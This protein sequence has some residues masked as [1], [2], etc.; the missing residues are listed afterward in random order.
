MIGQA[1]LHAVLRTDFYTFAQR[2]FREVAAGETF[3]PNWHIEAMCHVL[4][5]IGLK[6]RRRQ[7][8][9]VPPRSLKSVCSSVALVAWLLGHDPTRKIIC[10]SYS[11]DLASQF[12]A[13]TRQ[14]MKSSWYA[15]LFPGTVIS[16]G[17]DTERFFRTTAGGYRDSTSVGGTLTGKGADFIIIDDPAKP[18]EMM[19]EALRTSVNDWYDRTLTTR[20]N[21]KRTDGILLVMQRLHP[22][23][24]SGHVKQR[25]GWEVLTLP[26]IAMADETIPLSA[27][28]SH[29]RA[30]GD[31]LDEHREGKADLEERKL[32]LGARAFQAQY[33]Q[34]PL[35][36]DGAII[37][38]AKFKSF[39]VVP[40]LSSGKIV[41]SW[42]CASKSGEFNDFSVCTTWLIMNDSYFLLDIFREKLQFPDLI[43]ATCKLAEA[44]RP[45]DVLIE[46]AA[47]GT[48]LIQQLTFDRPIAMPRP[49]KIT[50]MRD[51]IT[52]LHTV[53]NVVEQGRVLLPLNA[54]WL[55]DFKIE[56]IQF[57]YG[58]FNDQI[59]SLSQ[60]LT[61]AE[62][63]RMRG[64]TIERIPMF[65][66]PV[67]QTR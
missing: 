20:L 65:G 21:N 10:I 36:A 25:G 17:K 63:K 1:E 45:D 54:T 47:A 38:W 4:G 11:Q 26:A 8:I 56:L 52:R 7:I 33:Q 49:V 64:A 37:E 48:Q 9:E 30:S 13:M 58:K 22:D 57:P 34:D 28:R 61:Y 62:A 32:E 44:W 31:V 15:E 35:A 43:R 3:T 60:F 5:E 51:K 42:D 16:P 55:D 50:P 6:R 39:G 40:K 12:S 41:Q 23:D 66:G 19:S 27:T 14:I 67:M 53:S 24:L 2:A 46:D 29:Q 59:D 18:D